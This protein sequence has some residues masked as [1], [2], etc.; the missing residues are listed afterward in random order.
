M[1]QL[2][3]TMA[4]D[5]DPSRDLQAITV[6]LA[7]EAGGPGAD[8]RFSIEQLQAVIAVAW[9]MGAEVPLNTLKGLRVCRICGCWE[10]QACDPP[11]SW[12]AADLCSACVPVAAQ[13]GLGPVNCG[14]C[15]RPAARVHI[16]QEC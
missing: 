15:R 14:V 1:N 8:G 4:R 13:H 3:K 11:C 6:R 12:V 7:G 5:W 2:A 16:C 10:L 9:K